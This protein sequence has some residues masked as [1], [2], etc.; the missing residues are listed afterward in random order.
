[1][2]AL[3]RG[4]ATGRIARDPHVA[5]NSDGSKTVLF[6]LLV[7][8]ARKNPTTGE[9]G[10]DAIPLVAWVRAETEGTG[11]WAHVG[12][13]DLIQVEYS[14]RSGSYADKATGE[15]RY[16]MQLSVTDMAFLES[17]T[18]TQQRRISHLQSALQGAQEAQQPEPAPTT[19][20]ARASRQKVS[21]AA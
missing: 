8:R 5:I 2:S 21:T 9:R 18:T 13:G 14:V 15:I 12:T 1:M 3:N 4:T 7:D 10:T 20:R 6:T 19:S 17:K 11:P 16:S